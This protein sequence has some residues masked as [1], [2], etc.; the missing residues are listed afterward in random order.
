M[1]HGFDQHFGRGTA[2]PKPGS[3]SPVTT[4]DNELLNDPV[5]KAPDEGRLGSCSNSGQEPT[6]Q[7]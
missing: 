5:G 1:K 6:R 3:A 4:R 7:K 2:T